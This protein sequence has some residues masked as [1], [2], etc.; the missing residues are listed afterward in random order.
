MKTKQN[1]Y[2][3]CIGL[4]ATAAIVVGQ[5]DHKHTLDANGK[6]A[7]HS[8]SAS[9]I[10]RASALVGT[11]APAFKTVDANG[12]TIT[13]K[14]LLKKPTLVVFIEKGCPCC[15]SGRPYI[16]RIHNYYRD[17]AN[18][19]GVVYGTQKDAAEWKKNS[20]P[21]FSVIADPGGKIAK[22]Y[23]AT[24]SL[25]T[26]LVG[27]EGK[28]LLSYAGYSA[29]MLKEVTAKIAKLAGIKDRNMQTAPAPQECTSGCELGM[30]EKMGGSK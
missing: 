20:K 18:V 23:G 2:L 15:K 13:L 19:V 8:T 4:L 5:E 21:Q 3:V 12:N 30:G 10:K 25:A 17:V 11:A 24:S 27:K 6:E 28:I 14:G 1:Y 7:G 9:A 26:R 16:D 22:S 29:P